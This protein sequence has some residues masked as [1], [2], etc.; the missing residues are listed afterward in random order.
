M[1]ARCAV[2]LT[3][4]AGLLI[5]SLK[6]SREPR[7]FK[8]TV[9][10]SVFNLLSLKRL[11]QLFHLVFMKLRLFLAHNHKLEYKSPALLL[12]IQAQTPLGKLTASITAFSVSHKLPGI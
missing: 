5:L 10:E 12:H 3:S 7:C 2:T 11:T 9:P 6:S 4:S 8:I 1:Q